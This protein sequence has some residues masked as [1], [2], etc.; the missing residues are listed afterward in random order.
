MHESRICSFIGLAR[1]AGAVEAG[2]NAVENVVRRGRAF[3]VVIAADASDNTV[4]KV[5]GLCAANDVKTVRFG[6][7]SGL[8]GILGREMFSVIAVTDRRFSDRIAEMIAS[9]SNQD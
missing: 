5:C 1:K 8:G 9:E 4:R 6:N 7:K 3:L 2:E